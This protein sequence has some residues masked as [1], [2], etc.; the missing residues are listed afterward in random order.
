[1]STVEVIAIV[2]VGWFLVSLLFAL[3]AG[4]IIQIHRC[5]RP[6]L[7]ETCRVPDHQDAQTGPAESAQLNEHAAIGVALR[8]EAV[9]QRRRRSV[10]Y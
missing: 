5:P 4:R 10:R 3:V 8:L 1:M 7:C 2:I 6:D 9:D